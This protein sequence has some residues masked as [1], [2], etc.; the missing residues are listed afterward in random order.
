MF[1]PLIHLSMRY[2]HLANTNVQSCNLQVLFLFG[3]D[4]LKLLKSAF[5]AVWSHPRVMSLCLGPYGPKSRFKDFLS[6]FCYFLQIYKHYFFFN[7][8]YDGEVCVGRIIWVAVTIP[9]H[10]DFL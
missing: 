6:N 5:G 7:H 2:F 1:T 9:L 8:E 4:R 3:K 10:S